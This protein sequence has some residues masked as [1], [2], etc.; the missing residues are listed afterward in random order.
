[1]CPS[2]FL[3]KSPSSTAVRQSSLAR[4]MHVSSAYIDSEVDWS[5]RRPVHRSVANLL[6]LRGADA[7]KAALPPLDDPSLYVPCCSG[8]V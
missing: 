2:P 3:K 5:V 1:V 4:Q 6:V 7:D 8:S